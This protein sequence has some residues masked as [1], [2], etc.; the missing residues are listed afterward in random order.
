[1]RACRPL[2]FPFAALGRRE[3]SRSRLGLTLPELLVAL[4]LLAVLGGL[5]LPLVS[6]S[7]EAANSA[8][9]IK[10]LRDISQAVF[11]YADD[12]NRNLVPALDR[13]HP[14]GSGREWMNTLREAGYVSIWHNHPENMMQCPSR[15]VPATHAWNGM[16][17]GMNFYPGFYSISGV[18]ADG[19]RD[20]FRKISEIMRPAQTLMVAETDSYYTINVRD[21]AYR[22]A[23]HHGVC[24]IVFF[25]G[26]LEARSEP[27]PVIPSAFYPAR[28]EAAPFY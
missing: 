19:G 15:K 26:H 20:S 24:H 3:V 1:M 7:R 9:C 27:L 10:N 17:Y 4:A 14:S 21:P 22:I 11:R 18:R 28:R 13:T 23:P 8:R 5:L 16:H 25:D 12:H 6:R 2:V